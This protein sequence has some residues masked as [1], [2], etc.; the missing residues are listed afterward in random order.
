MGA[1]ALRVPFV[2]P[3]RP[4]VARSAPFI[5]FINNGGTRRLQPDFGGYESPGSLNIYGFPFATVGGDQ[6]KPRGSGFGVSPVFF[7]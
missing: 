3:K 6:P 4:L 1:R 2:A 7:G 5:A